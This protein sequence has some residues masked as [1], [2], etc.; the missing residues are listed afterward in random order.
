MRKKKYFCKWMTGIMLL[1]SLCVAGCGQEGGLTPVTTPGGEGELT[2]AAT[3]GGE[4]ELTPAA[5]P[6][7]EGEL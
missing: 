4:G 6:D 3:P 5:T 7:G 2:P 1:L